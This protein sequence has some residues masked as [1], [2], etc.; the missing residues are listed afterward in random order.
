MSFPASQAG[1]RGVT[2]AAALVWMGFGTA[3]AQTVP[4]EEDGPT[5]LQPPLSLPETLRGEV[6]SPGRTADG[7][8]VDTIRATFPAVG[9]CWTPPAG[10]T[11]LETVEIT[12]RF[13]LR[14]DGS[15]IGAPRVTFATA[16]AETRARQRLAAAAIEAIHRCTPLKLTKGFGDAVAGRPIA[17]R[18]IYQGPKGQ[19]V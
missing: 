11:K 17:I 1:W 19:G 15:V 4:F 18:F 6:R 10:L 12:V 5:F 13:S 8:E 14:R 16:G 7:R 9:S 3:A 2:V